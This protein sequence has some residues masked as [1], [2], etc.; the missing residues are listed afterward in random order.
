M[1]LTKLRGIEQSFSPCL[2]VSI[3]LEKIPLAPK[4]IT[5]VKEDKEGKDLVCA[6]PLSKGDT[7][8]PRGIL[9]GEDYPGGELRG[10][11]SINSLSTACIG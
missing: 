2:M 8:K 11:L 9:V 1:T 3:R 5:L 6:V 10:I 4:A 7:A